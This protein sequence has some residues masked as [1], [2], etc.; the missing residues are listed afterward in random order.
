MDLEIF[1]NNKEELKEDKVLK[2]LSFSSDLC[3]FNETS[4][5]GNFHFNEIITKLSKERE[6]NCNIRLP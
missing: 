3:G 5:D 2:E 4:Y 6:T 1:N